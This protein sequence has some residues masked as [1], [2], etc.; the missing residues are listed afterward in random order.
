MSAAARH[1]PWD[2]SRRIFSYRFPGEVEVTVDA[3]HP[4]KRV[5]LVEARVTAL[6]RDVVARA[7]RIQTGPD[8]SPQVAL[9]RPGLGLGQPAPPARLG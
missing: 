6:G 7:W 9:A 8:S 2:G 5:E 4:G 3:L 1:W